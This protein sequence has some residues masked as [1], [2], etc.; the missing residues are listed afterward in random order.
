MLLGALL[1]VLL[2][3]L[4]R[5]LLGALLRVLLRALL[6][7]LLGA[8]LRVLLGALLRVLSRNLLDIC[9]KSGS[10]AVPIG[11]R[12]SARAIDLVAHRPFTQAV[13]FSSPSLKVVS[14]LLV[15]CRLTMGRLQ[16]TLLAMYELH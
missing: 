8:L 3:A 15:C 7:E 12:R 2:G 1:R 6:R 5:V 9:S 13:L 16:P 14:T 4:L 10:L 11:A